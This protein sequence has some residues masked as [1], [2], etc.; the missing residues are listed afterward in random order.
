ML[1]AGGRHRL[2]RRAAAVAARLAAPVATAAFIGGIALLAGAL[3]W[4]TVVRAKR[5]ERR[6]VA[7]ASGL[8]RSLAAAESIIRAEPQVLLFWE[9]GQALRVVAHTLNGIPGLPDSPEKLLRFGQWLEPSSAAALK[10][11]LDALFTSGQPFNIIVRTMAG[12]HVEAEGR[13]A[14]GRAVLRLRDVAGHQRRGRPHPRP[15]PAPRPRNAR[16]PRAARRAADPGVAAQQGR[17]PH[18]GQQRLRAG[19][20]GAQRARGAASARS[21]CWSSASAGAAAR[22]WRAAKATASACPSSSAA[23]A[24][25]TT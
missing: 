4:L 24:S 5:D 23:S 22:V 2:G 21:S 25:R 20:R 8:K 10:P 18:L 9:Q 15:A 14:G 17:P 19:R 12:G 11:A 13:A 6:A 3:I 7:E 16:Q 1:V